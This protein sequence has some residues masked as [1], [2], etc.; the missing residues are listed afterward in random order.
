MAIWNLWHGCHKISE[1]CRNCYVYRMDTKYEKDPS[2]VFKTNNFDLPIKKN[3][4]GEY[5]IKANELVYTCF[6]S[7]FFLEDADEWRIDAW[8]IIKERSD[9]KFLIVT[10]RIDRFNINLPSDWGNGYDNVE[11]C[12]TVENQDRADYRL[13]IFLEMPIKSK[14][15]ICEPLLEKIDLSK[16]LNSSIKQVVVGGE[17]GNEARICNYDWI[18]EIRNECIRNNVSFSFKQTGAKFIKDGKMY[19]INRK[20]QH[21][22]AKKANINT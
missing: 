19:R 4:K 5:K 2:K 14:S 11:I 16:Y 10:K 17:S 18:I 3:R 6:T 12:C 22:N 20:Y 7:D 1:G 21:S 15:I 13:P 9:L 8:K